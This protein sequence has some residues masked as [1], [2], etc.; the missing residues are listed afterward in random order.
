MTLSAAAVVGFWNLVNRKYSPE[1]EAWVDIGQRPRWFFYGLAVLAFGL[2]LVVTVVTVAQPWWEPGDLLR[3]P[4]NVAQHRITRT[5]SAEGCCGSEVGAVS[6]LGNLI[7][8]G[9]AAMMGFAGIQRAL[10]VGKWDG[11]VI[12]LLL[13]ACLATVLALDDLFRLHES[14]QRK[15]IVFYMTVLG[16]VACLS[17]L[18]LSW[19][20]NGFLLA[21]AGFFAASIVV[22][23][24]FE[25]NFGEYRI[26]IEDAAKLFGFCCLACF[27][28]TAGLRLSGSGS[29]GDPGS[30]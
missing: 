8:T 9:A 29:T 5:G 15:F 1:N 28:L 17:V 14:H 11:G 2:P 21:T 24:I 10:K 22:D 6:L 12:L 18:W 23:T 13:G 19:F 26:V 20:E 25:H 16:A 4:L 30:G 7:T 27:A 3:D